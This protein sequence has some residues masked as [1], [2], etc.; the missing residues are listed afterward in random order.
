[1]NPFYDPGEM[2]R[3]TTREA[4]QA[5]ID[6][7]KTPSVRSVYA[8]VGGKYT[9]LVAECRLLRA[10]GNTTGEAEGNGQKPVQRKTYV[11]TRWPRLHVAGLRFRDGTYTTSD[12]E[13]QARIEGLAYFGVHIHEE[14]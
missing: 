1:M 9:R 4:W 11:C 14:G 2:V 6:E 8:R 10:E 7:G 3:T 13:E 12:A 5:L